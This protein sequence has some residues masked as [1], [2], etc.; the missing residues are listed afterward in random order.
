MKV[1]FWKT[2]FTDIKLSIDKLTHPCYDASIGEWSKYR[3]TSIGGDVFIEDYLDQFSARETYADFIKRRSITYCPAHAKS[4]V[5]EI[6]NA[7]QCKLVDVVRKSGTDSYIRASNGDLRGVD[8]CGST[9]TGFIVNDV[10][11]DLL[12]I[13]KVAVYVD[14]EQIPEGSTVSDVS[15]KRPYLYKYAAEDILSWHY[16]KGILTSVLLRDTLEKVDEETGLVTGEYVEYRVLKLISDGVQVAICDANGVI[17]SIVRL[18]LKIIPL[19]IFEITQSLLVDV[20]N[21]QIALLN[22]ASSDMNYALKANFPFYTEQYDALADLMNLRQAVTNPDTALSEPFGSNGESVLA[23][24]AKDSEIKVGV[25]QGRRYPKGLERPGFINPS[26]EPLNASMAKQSQLKEEIRQLIHLTLQ[27]VKSKSDPSDSD[28]AGGLESGLANIGFELAYGERQIAQIWAQYEGKNDTVQIIYP[29]NYSLK[30]DEDRQKEAEAL[31]K[32]ISSSPSV[33][34]Q[35]EIA[36]EIVSTTIGH[37]VSQET[38]KKI[39]T[40]IDS[41]LQVVTTVDDII[42]DH[43]HGFVSTATASKIRGYSEKEAELAKQDHAERAARIVTAQMNAAG[44]KNAAARG[45][46]DLDDEE[47]DSAKEEKK[48]SRDSSSDVDISKKV[49]GKG[50]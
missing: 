38:L 41:A 7:I 22:L 50:K 11:P 8:F 42:K 29:Q 23:Q 13:G 20:A 6:K 32:E 17:K 4:G 26:A 14:R 37:K 36:K 10:L 1:K 33:T 2:I 43:E 16:E 31:R 19:V 30:T 34:Y 15:E 25:S 47:D 9:M 48:Q 27:S 45:A 24:R 46:D 28:N 12:N 35:K 49:R 18:S 21:Y 3:S 44:I 39:H 40:E 5:L